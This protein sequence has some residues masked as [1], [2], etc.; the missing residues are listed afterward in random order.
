MHHCV[1]KYYIL[2][3]RLCR[4]FTAQQPYIWHQLKSKN[5][6]LAVAWLDYKKVYYDSVP[7]NWIAHCLQLLHFD[8]PIISCVEKL[9][10]LYT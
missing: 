5:C 3:R 8:S 2:P 1:V 4:S 9:L 10:P 6:S 7:H